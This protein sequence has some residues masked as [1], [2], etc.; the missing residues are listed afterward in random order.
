M[1]N[2][3]GDYPENQVRPQRILITQLARLGDV[4]QTWPLVK[5]LRRVHSQARLALLCDAAWR[6]LA[7]LGPELDELHTLDMRDIAHLARSQPEAAYDRLSFALREV[8]S[9]DVDLM[10]NLN[11]SRVALLLAHLMGAPVKGYRPAAGGRE[12]WR[13]PWLALVYGL[14][15]A[16]VFNR[17]HLSDV[18]RHLGPPAPGEPAAPAAPSLSGTPVIAL[19]LSTRHGKRSWPLA[20]FTRLARQLIDSWGAEIWLLGTA[21]ERPLGEELQK[22]LPGHFREQVIN[23]Q[24]RTDLAELAER[25]KAAHLV[26]SGDTGTLH[27]AASLGARVV[28]IFLGPASCFE[29]GPYGA[30]HQVIQA[31]PVCHPCMEA[32]PECSEPVCQQMITAEQVVGVVSAVLGKEEWTGRPPAGVRTYQSCMDE[33]GVHYAIRAGGPPGWADLAGWAYR[34]AGARLLGLFPLPAPFPAPFLTGADL[35]NLQDLSKALRNGATPPGKPA[36]QEALRP[37]WALG[38]T[39]EHQA[40]WQGERHDF[41]DWFHRMKAA[42]GEE[43]ENIAAQARLKV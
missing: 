1:E 18:F 42:L 5:H 2:Y 33:L 34:A 29:T 20:H 9:R 23:L 26:V 35:Q 24:G 17:L 41:Q 38:S 25:L 6:D 10:Y 4:V 11:F 28:G 16:R 37:L 30:G 8:R 43:L 19:Q 36:V 13:E 12:F 15:H 27:L 32:G 40:S 22:S 21:E 31:E 39:L 14:V 3:A 7:S